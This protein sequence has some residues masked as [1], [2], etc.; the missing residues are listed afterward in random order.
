[1]PEASVRS[2]VPR[3]HASLCTGMRQE[4]GGEQNEEG[5]PAH[6]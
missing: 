5:R 4:E 3:R 2:K 1:M 6:D